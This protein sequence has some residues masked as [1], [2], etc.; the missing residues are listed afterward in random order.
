MA[1]LHR[2]SSGLYLLSFRYDGRQFQRSLET[3]NE[4][5]ASRIRQ[6]VERRF[7]LFRDGTL[8]L[9]DGVAPDELWRVLLNGQVPQVAS[10]LIRVINLKTAAE[11]YLKSYPTGSKEAQTLKTEEVHLNNFS[12]VLGKATS[13][14]SIGPDDIRRYID[15]RLVEKGNRGGTIKSDTVR[16]ELQTFRLAWRFAKRQGNVATNC[17]VDDVERPKRRQ[18]PPFQTWEQIDSV[19]SRGKLTDEQ[20]AELWDGLYLRELE[21]ADFLEHVR[22]V[23]G[24]LPRFVYIY[25]TLCF[26]AYTGARRSEMFRAQIEDVADGWITLREKK[27]NLD[28]KISFRSI[29]LNGELAPILDS[30]L[31]SHPGGRQLFCKT[32]GQ[33]LDDRTSREAFAAVTKNS[34]WNVLHGYHVL[35]HSFASNLARSGRASGAEIDELMGHE[36]EEMRYRYQHLFPEDRM[37]AVNLLSFR[38]NPATRNVSGVRVGGRR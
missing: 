38:L 14:D 25:P 12:R 2:R 13:L 33:P 30:W 18:K 9:P 8:R 35:R 34:K 27:R 11:Q 29:P 37:R 4:E 6:N 23:G 7:K 3:S 1:S 10:K 28:T 36:T 20:T 31:V 17:P 15:A 22:Q 26:C 16:K 21:I 19:I 32:N 5:E 24:S